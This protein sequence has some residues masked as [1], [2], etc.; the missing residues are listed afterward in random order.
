[1]KKRRSDFFGTSGRGRSKTRPPRL[2]RLEERRLLVTIVVNTTGDGNDPTAG[3]LS[4]REAIEI[5]NGSLAISAL[6]P[7]AQTQVSGAL[8]SSNTIDFAIASSNGAPSAILL[9]SPLPAITN[10]V[11][12]DGYTEPGAQPDTNGPGA[13]DNAVLMVEINGSEAGVGAS[14]FV[15][16]AGGSTVRGLIISFFDGGSAIEIDSPGG[17]NISGNLLGSVLTSSTSTVGGGNKNGV[18]ILGSSG[19]TVGGTTDDAP[20]IITG[21]AA[22]GVLIANSNGGGDAADNV[23]ERNFIG[24]EPT[25][26]NGV[27]NGG[28]GVV[29][30]AS[31]TSGAGSVTGTTISGN[32]IAGSGYGTAIARSTLT[33]DDA[34]IL[35]EGSLVSGNTI[36]GN[37]IGTDITGMTGAAGMAEQFLADGINIDGAVDTMIGG[38]APGAAN[39][40]AFNAGVGVNVLA[41]TGNTISRN[42]IFQNGRLLADPLF[43]QVGGIDVGDDGPTPNHATNPLPGPNNFQ[44]FPLISSVTSS[45]SSTIVTGMLQSAPNTVYTIEFFSNPSADPSGYGQGQTFLGATSVTTDASGNATLSAANATLPVAVAAGSFVSATATDPQGDTSEFSLELP[46]VQLAVSPSATTVN[47]GDTVTYTYTVTNAGG[48]G[49]VNS[50][51]LAV[52]RN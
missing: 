33:D 9:A 46:E 37:K 7:Q 44:N 1:M 3:T 39:T 2:E 40:I 42:A 43:P 28:P 19:N 13:A 22:D 20:N 32:I 48:G 14:G 8:A 15:L 35:L 10:P 25:G 41:G 11:V 27:G 52:R 17:D 34:N 18:S 23:V 49:Q 5:S 6:S 31:T 26:E 30:S 50:V 21:N 45:G 16:A 38:S 29:L 51:S 47:L 24:L 4:L 36:I 12:I